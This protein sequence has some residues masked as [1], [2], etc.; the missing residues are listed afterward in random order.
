MGD[1]RPDNGS[2]PDDGGSRGLP[3]LPPEWG[4]VVIPDD[5]S[6]LA[7]EAQALRREMRGTARRA[8]VR[9][10]LGLSTDQ[11]ASMGIPVVIMTVAILTTL[12][13]L[14]VVTW[15]N[16][17]GGVYPTGGETTSQHTVGPTSPAAG[18]TTPDT[19]TALT[20]LTFRNSAGQMVRLADLMPMIILLVDGCSCQPLITGLSQAVPPGVKVVPVTASGAGQSSGNAAP[21]AGATSSGTPSPD[22]ANVVRLIDPAGTLRARFNAPAPDG[23]ATAVVLSKTGTIV[24]TIPHASAFTDIKP[25]NPG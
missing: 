1:L 20:E 22:P 19:H 2:P 6:E 7:A 17:P 11:S 4:T 5:P 3:D 21:S 24:A 16:Q 25:L 13:S 14:L 9:K 10:L 15:G 8:R 18:G 23:K 12:V